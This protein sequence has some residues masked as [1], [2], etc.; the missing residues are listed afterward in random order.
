MYMVWVAI[1]LRWTL[2]IRLSRRSF[3]GIIT[4]KMIIL[5]TVPNFPIECQL[6]T[7]LLSFNTTQVRI[8]FN[9]KIECSAQYFSLYI[10]LVML[11]FQLLYESG[12]SRRYSYIALAIIHVLIIGTSTF[13]F[14]PSI[15][16]E[17]KA[18]R[19]KSKEKEKK[20]I[21][22]EHESFITNTEGM[23]IV[24]LHIIW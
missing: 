17:P 21:H 15:S 12:V 20:K 22:T 7:F 2:D 19:V 1:I 16:I 24:R 4:V 11:Y 10:R 3:I 9:W 8:S 23:D 6:I 13:C 5:T 14:L 18:L